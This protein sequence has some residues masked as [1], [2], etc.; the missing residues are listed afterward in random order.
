LTDTDGDKAKAKM[1]EYKAE[2]SAKPEK[3]ILGDHK[4]NH[5]QYNRKTGKAVHA[6]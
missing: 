3:N 2:E 6:P 4:E 5:D 1:Q